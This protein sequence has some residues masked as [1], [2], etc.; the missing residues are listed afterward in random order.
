[1]NLDTRNVVILDD[2]HLTSDETKKTELVAAYNRVL[3]RI[4]KHPHLIILASTLNKPETEQQIAKFIEADNKP[5][6][7]LDYQHEVANEIDQL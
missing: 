4:N 6:Q 7:L 5:D 3:K 2:Q 1:M